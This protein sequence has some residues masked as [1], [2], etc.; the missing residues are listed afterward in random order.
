[1]REKTATAGRNAYISYQ[2]W[3]LV[4]ARILPLNPDQI[5]PEYL[6][7]RIQDL[8]EKAEELDLPIDGMVL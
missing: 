6:D 5:S 3:A 7:L 4:P 2:S 1:M 8:K